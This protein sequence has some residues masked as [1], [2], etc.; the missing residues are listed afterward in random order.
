MPGSTIGEIVDLKVPDGTM[1]VFTTRGEVGGVGAGDWKYPAVIV[2]QEAFGANDQIQGWSRR[3]AAEGYYTAAPVLYHRNGINP[4]TAYDAQDEFMKLRLGIS[5]DAMVTDLTALMD[6]FKRS[7]NVDET[8]VGIVGFCMGGTVSFMAAARVPGIKAAAVYYGNRILVPDVEGGPTLLDE[9]S[10]IKG[11]L[12]GFF[13][14]LDAGMTGEQLEVVKGKLKNA[15]VDADINLY[16]GA[17]H[18]FMRD[19]DPG[20]FNK[21][22]SDDAWEKTLAFFKKNL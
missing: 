9:A 6:Y 22:A 11:P 16:E 1:R 17:G 14:A 8:R 2:I 7:P 19:D 12:I 4:T 18:G 20:V 5:N 10:N 21:A 3:L 13:G 15:G